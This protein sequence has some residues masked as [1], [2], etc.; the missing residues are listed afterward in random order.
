M[1]DT[2]TTTHSE[3]GKRL[4]A[5]KLYREYVDRI[6][7]VL[8]WIDERKRGIPGANEITARADFHRDH[9][10]TSYDEKAQV[11][12]LP[13]STYLVMLLLAKDHWAS[14]I[15]PLEKWLDKHNIE[16]VEATKPD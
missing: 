14:M 3:I 12:K 9:I 10:A 11:V 5:L 8:R 15:T 7:H 6:D 13:E 1:T 2:D 4:D 16:H